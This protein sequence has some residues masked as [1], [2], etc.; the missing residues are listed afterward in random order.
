MMRKSI[1]KLFTCTLAI[2]L[3]GC[4]SGQNDIKQFEFNNFS[5]FSK[6][7]NN[8]INGS[9]IYKD[10]ENYYFQ[11]PV[12]ETLWYSN[13]CFKTKNRLG[14][15]DEAVFH[16]TIVD[17]TIYY[18]AI[19]RDTDFTVT[20]LGDRNPYGGA[21]CE[22]NMK[23]NEIKELKRFKSGQIGNLIVDN[24]W[25][26]YSIF[27]NCTGVYRFNSETND[28]EKL[29]QFSP[30]N[31]VLADNALV[32]L[33][34]GKIMAYDL[35]TR[36]SGVLYKI[37]LSR[38]EEI[39]NF[40]VHDDCIYYFIELFSGNKITT[41]TVQYNVSAKQSSQIC[42]M[43][44]SVEAATIYGNKIIYLSSNSMHNEKFDAIRIVNIDDGTL[45]REVKQTAIGDGLFI[46]DNELY[47]YLY[48]FEKAPSIVRI[49]LDS[50]DFASEKL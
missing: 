39:N 14:R 19:N 30:D 49:N 1:I 6:D 18:F 33:Q 16:I 27:G 48:E 17:K 22:L 28:S 38:N 21:I 25:I 23:T 45:V 15:L 5:K 34:G 42:S 47:F 9:L 44:Y 13:N 37:P 35:E 12:D 36:T 50:Q 20:Y 31:L 29:I 41:K 46:F 26:Y 2:M 10:N 7:S 4:S 32:Y 43:D 11:S 8:I 24:Q 3:C 40:I